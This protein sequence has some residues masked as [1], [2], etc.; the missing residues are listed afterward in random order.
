MAS[1]GLQHGEI[2]FTFVG[3]CHDST[4]GVADVDRI[5]GWPFV[6]DGTSHAAVGRC[7]SRIG[8]QRLD[9]CCSRRWGCQGGPLVARW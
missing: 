6:Q 4:I 7:T 3:G 5:A 2:E 8:I 9:R 1:I